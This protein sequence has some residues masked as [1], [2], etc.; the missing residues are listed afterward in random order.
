MKHALLAL[1]AVG[2][3]TVSASAR[4]MRAPLTAEQ[5]KALTP[6]EVLTKLMEGNKRYVAG[7]LT[8]MD[9]PSSIEAAAGGQFPMAVILSC[10]DSRVPVESVFDQGIGDI[11]VGRVAGN[12]ENVDL[13]GSFEF[14]T[15][16]AGARLLMVLGHESCGAV[17]G[18][19]DNVELGNLTELLEK[20]QPAVKAAG[21]NFPED[22]RTTDNPEFVNKVIEENARI[23][24]DDIR[25][26]SPILAE[27][28][29]NGDIKIVGALYKINN[30][31]VVLL[32]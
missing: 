29:K 1:P 8:E 26:G 28:E 19:C 23:T 30:G 5:Q 12:V 31:E 20:I 14:A 3:M 24:I 6:D 15:K 13:L 32:D 16:A 4:D 22:Q 25:K 17:K 21:K 10:L 11:F 7:E 2:C 18:A 27:L 9:I